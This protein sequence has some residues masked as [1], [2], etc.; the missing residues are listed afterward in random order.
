MRRNVL[1]P[2]L[3]SRTVYIPT[4]ATRGDVATAVAAADS[5]RRRSARIPLGPLAEGLVFAASIA[6]ALAAWQVISVTGPDLADRPALDDRYVQRAVVAHAH[7]RLLDRVR[8][9]GPRLGARARGRHGAGRAAGDLPRLQ[10]LRGPGVPGP[11]RVPAPDPVGGPDPAALPHAR[12]DAEERGLP[13]RLRGL[14]AAAD[15]DDLRRARRRPAGDGHRPVVRAGPA[16]APL[17]DHAAERDPVHRHRAADLVYRVADPGLHGGALHGRAG[18]GPEGQLRRLLRP[19]HRAV[20]LRGRDRLPRR[21]H[22]P[23]RLAPS[24]GAR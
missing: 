16:R 22:P 18:P 5:R 11:D 20:R 17:P 10:R 3:G 19:E 13:R 21:R 1:I 8:A 12:H 24:S 2:N 4:M 6:A 7:E 14:L 23:D 9:D 15:P